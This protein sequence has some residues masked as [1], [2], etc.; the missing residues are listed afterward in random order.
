M[1]TRN[2]EAG[3]ECAAAPAGAGARRQPPPGVPGSVAYVE[4]TP[5]LPYPLKGR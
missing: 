2:P 1:I 3:A 5:A 4:L